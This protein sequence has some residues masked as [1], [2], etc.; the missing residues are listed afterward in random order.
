MTNSIEE[1]AAEKLESM[2]LIMCVLPDDGTDL[3]LIRSLHQ[4]KGIDTADS[5]G[6]RGVSVFKESDIKHSDQ[7]GDNYF[8]KLVHIV[9]PESEA[10]ILFEYVYNLAQI[11]RPNGGWVGLSQ[12]IYATPFS[13]PKNLQEEADL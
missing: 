12:P 7:M 5:T 13:L 10:D 9:V 1:F 8:V 4:E 2:R 6:C 11:D 3:M